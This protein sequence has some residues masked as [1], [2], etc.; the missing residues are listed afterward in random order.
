MKFYYFGGHLSKYEI[1]LLENSGFSGV[2]FTYDNQQ[3]DFFTKIANTIDL[4]QKIKYMVAI[5]A[6]TISPQYLCMI[7]ESMNSIAP[8]RLQ[9]NLISG[10]TKEHEAAFGGIVG[11]VNDLS[12]KIEKSEYLIKFLHSLNT[13]KPKVNLKFLMPDFYVSTTNEFVFDV[14][15]QYNNK[16]IIQHREYKKGT[17]TTYDEKNSPTE[18]KPFSLENKPVM[19]SIGPRLRRT[20]EEIDAIPKRRVSN[21]TDYFTYDQFKEFIQDLEQKGINEILM[22]FWPVSERDYGIEFV[23]EYT[24]IDNNQ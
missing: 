14:A 18:G 21:D 23:R 17:W 15:N 5:R 9:V 4:S 12:S 2:L 7:N 11:D 10:H 13:I 24:G 8:G 6:Y 22:F 1:D 19:L 16:M 3:G 20:Q